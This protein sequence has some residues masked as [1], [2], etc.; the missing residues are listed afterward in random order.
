MKIKVQTCWNG[1]GFVFRAL[2]CGGIR[3]PSEDGIWRRSDATLMLNVLEAEGFERSKIR[4][5]HV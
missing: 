2:V 3:I 1:H 5:N 4:F